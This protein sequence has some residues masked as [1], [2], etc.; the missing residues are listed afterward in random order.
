MAALLIS[1]WS[2]IA[3]AEDQ[4]QLETAKLFFQAGAA[5]YQRTEFDRAIDEFRSAYAISQRPAILYN[6]ARCHERLA[7]YR[8]AAAAFRSYLDATPGAEDRTEIQG[9]IALLES[10]IGSSNQLEP[11]KTRFFEGAAKYEREDFAGAIEDF[12]E[13][14]RLSKRVDLLYNIARCQERL[15]HWDDAIATLLE[16]LAQRPNADDRS[17]VERR[18]ARFEELRAAS[19]PKKIIL[20]EVP[21]DHRPWGVRHRN[22]LIVGGTTL[23]LFATSL[24]TGLAAHQL[25]GDLTKSCLNSGCDGGRRD[26]IQRERQLGIASDVFMGIAI[27]AAVATIVIYAVETRPPKTDR[28]QAPLGIRFAGLGVAF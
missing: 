6:I 22:S 28:A 4:Q 23:A 3:R 17:Q 14:L 12:R 16:Y 19:Q 5:H 11:A 15:G 24:G 2:S 13:A 26:D 7:Q 10:L 25:D 20:R 21:V 18:I 9:R 1:G 27:A 8:E